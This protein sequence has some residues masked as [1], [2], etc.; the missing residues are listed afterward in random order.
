MDA[1]PS[2]A[3]SRNGKIPGICC[4]QAFF[5]GQP[6]GLVAHVD[7]VL[8]SREVPPGEPQGTGG[9]P[10]IL[11]GLDALDSQC[12]VLDGDVC[13]E[14]VHGSA[15]PARR[16]DFHLA[17]QTQTLGSVPA[18][19]GSSHGMTAH[20]QP[21]GLALRRCAL[22]DLPVLQDIRHQSGLRLG[23]GTGSKG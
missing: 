14:V 21:D 6:G 7:L 22:P 13:P 2:A 16:L 3:Q 23:P 15:V 19:L 11:L 8:P 4:P 10:L 20:A 18:D 9:I 12:V 1:S 17:L 5:D